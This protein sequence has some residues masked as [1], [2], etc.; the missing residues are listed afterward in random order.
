MVLSAVAVLFLGVSR[1]NPPGFFRDESAIALNARTIAER[2]EDE[3]GSSWPLYFRS[4]GDYK[5]PTYVYALAGVFAVWEPGIV[6]ARVLSALFGLAGVLLLGV[7]VG[8]L[9]S[10]VAGVLTAVAAGLNPWLFEVSR[11]VFEVALLPLAVV[12]SLLAVER[13]RT[14]SRWSATDVVPLGASFGLMAYTYP[15]GRL[16]APLLALGLAVWVRRVGWRSVATAW[17]AVAVVLV[18][19]VAYTLVHPGALTSRYRATTYVSGDLSALEI[20]RRF[21]GHYVANLDLWTW[22]VVGDSNSRHHV[23]GGGSILAGIAL[24]AV[25]GF[26]VAVAR[27]RHDPWWRF[28]LYALAVSVVPASL[29]VDRFHT[30]RLVPFGVLLLLF[31]GLGI[32]TLV[33]TRPRR[34][35]LIAGGLV[36]ILVAGQALYFQERYRTL[37]DERRDAFEAAYPDVLRAAARRGPVYVRSEDET[38]AHALWYGALQRL[39]PPVRRLPPGA[40]VPPGGVLVGELDPCRGC[41]LVDRREPFSAYQARTSPSP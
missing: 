18:P 12:L 10:P 33:E 20:A 25:L 4:F 21:L 9:T 13:L 14:R 3:Y 31:A 27:R 36:S 41:I 17:L 15:T 35:T 6:A 39:S 2:G 22:V 8:R 11:L 40:P 28:A 23:G 24:L 1:S 34:A 16:F 5:S 19:I 32:A 7:L 37:D 26:V 29:T 30:L 38:S